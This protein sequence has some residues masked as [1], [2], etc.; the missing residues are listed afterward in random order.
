MALG[1]RPTSRSIMARLIP[2][3]VKY[4]TAGSAANCCRSAIPQR[5]GDEQH[6]GQDFDQRIPRADADAAVGAPTAQYQPAQQRNVVPDSDP[7]AAGRA[8]RGWPQQRFVRRDP[9]DDDVQKRADRQ[10]QHGDHERSVGA[11][12]SALPD[13]KMSARASSDQRGGASGT[14]VTFSL[15]ITGGE[16]R[17]GRTRPT[18][19]SRTCTSNRY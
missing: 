16:D 8:V 10:P 18:R 13:G 5:H 14:E 2:I 6:G 7:V 12:A 11:I 3:A 1:S 17:V 19:H 15:K 9:I 4:S